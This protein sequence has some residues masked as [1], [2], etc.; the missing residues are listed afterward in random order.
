M[1]GKELHKAIETLSEHLDAMDHIEKP[2]C[3]LANTCKDFI[4]VSIAFAHA[5][6]KI[7][8]ERHD[9]YARLDLLIELCS[10]E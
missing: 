6:E 7:L 4:P 9:L 2:L 8:K 3:I 5:K 1:T 10:S